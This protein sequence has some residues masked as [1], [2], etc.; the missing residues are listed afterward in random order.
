MV[1]GKAAL[2][3]ELPVVKTFIEMRQPTNEAPVSE[4]PPKVRAEKGS[5]SSQASTTL[6]SCC[7]KPSVS[8]ETTGGLGLWILSQAGAL[9]LLGKKKQQRR[10][11]PS[12]PHIL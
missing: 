11:N 10:Q 7:P 3:E 9:S 4:D 12:L 2:G 5:L 1:R 6:L 8:R